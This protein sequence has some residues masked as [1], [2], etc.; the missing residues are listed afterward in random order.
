[1]YRS[2]V[3]ILTCPRENWI[4]WSLRRPH[5]ASGHRYDTDRAEQHGPDRIRGPGLR[6]AEMTFGLKPLVPIRRALLIA[7]KIGPGQPTKGAEA[8]PNHQS[9]SQPSRFLSRP[10]ASGGYVN[11]EFLACAEVAQL[12]F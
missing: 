3:C 9:G 4:C 7:R 8:I 10:P 12:Q 11:T 5:D 1:R 2:V 6:D